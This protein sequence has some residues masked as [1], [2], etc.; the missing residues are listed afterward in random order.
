[1]TL[2]YAALDTLNFAKRLEAVGVEPK[3]A[4]VQAEL[5]LEILEKQ[6]QAYEK[7]VAKFAEYRPV[8]DE[9]K[10]TRHEFAT[11]GDINN[12]RHALKVDINNLYNVLT[13][14]INN[15][16]NVLT[17]DINNLSSELKTEINTL[18]SKMD[19]MRNELIIKL[20]GVVVASSSVLGVIMAFL[21]K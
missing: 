12:L 8:L 1:M 19:N 16:C 20:G 7:V 5:Q 9:I 11:K 15:L 17:V 14:D 18:E 13:V 4:E 21:V 10:I 3:V 2:A 6:A